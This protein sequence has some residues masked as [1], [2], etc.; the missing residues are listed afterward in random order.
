MIDSVS[1]DLYPI[2]IIFL[3]ARLAALEVADRA[4]LNQCYHPPIGVGRMI[5]ILNI[6]NFSTKCQLDVGPMS[7]TFAQH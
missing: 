6:H 5:W 2:P 7:A 1:V 3:T 4:L